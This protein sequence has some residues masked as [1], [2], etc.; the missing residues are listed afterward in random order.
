MSIYVWHPNYLKRQCCV[1][2][3]K[4]IFNKNAK[5]KVIAI[6]LEGLEIQCLKCKYFYSD[7]YN[8]EFC[9]EKCMKKHIKF[10]KHVDKA[11][12]TVTCL[13]CKTKTAKNELFVGKVDLYEFEPEEDVDFEELDPFSDYKGTDIVNTIS[14]Q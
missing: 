3:F 12:L 5:E 8:A 2:C 14:I 9:S 4:D 1:S 7:P 10:E 13:T 6:S 11:H